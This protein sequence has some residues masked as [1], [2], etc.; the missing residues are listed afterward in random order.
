MPVSPRRRL[1]NPR[2]V[3]ALLL[4]L[5]LLGVSAIWLNVLGVGTRFENLVDKVALIV[6]PPPDRPI[7][8]EVLVTPEPTEAPTPTPVPT[9]RPPLAPGQTEPPPPTPSPAPVR[10]AVDVDL[11]AD[12]EAAFI[13]EKDKDMCAVA[14]TQMVL[15]MHGKAV[16]TDA[17]QRELAGR[18]DEWESR[19]DSKNGGWGPSAMVKA[20]EAYGVAGYE[21][22]AYETRQDALRDS[23]KA[24]QETGAPVLLLSW[25]GAHTWVMTGFRAN[26]DP[27]L[28][29]DAKVSGAY[30]LDPWY[31]RISSIWGPSDKPGTFQDAAEMK[32]NYLPWKRPEGLYPKRDGLFIAV[33]PTLPLTPAP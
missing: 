32:R 5:A 12:P 14:G 18:I 23:A 31:P 6:D 9:P 30:I 15:A 8:D 10:E 20:L 3:V 27:L 19:R 33:V 16:L 11:L 4:A 17:F 21:V 28:F 25:R 22:R 1:I 13:S 2:R 7:E 29:A 26:A 24:L